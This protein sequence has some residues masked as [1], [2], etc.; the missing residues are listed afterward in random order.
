MLLI[1]VLCSVS[2]EADLM[3]EIGTT[4]A[5]HQVK[6]QGPSFFQG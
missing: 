2:Q 6:F 1:P 3:H 4:P 5:H